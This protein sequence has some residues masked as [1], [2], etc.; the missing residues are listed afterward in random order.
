MKNKE[1]WLPVK[2]YEGM[3]Q[4]SNLGSVK[5]LSRELLNWGLYPFFSKEKILKPS[6]NNRGYYTVNLHKNKK[7]KLRTVHQLVAEAFLNHKPCGY[8]L[9]VNHIDQNRLNNNI[10][11]LEVVTQ[12]ENS[13]KRHLKSTSK[14]TGVSYDKLRRKWVS[15]ITI[16]GNQINLG[17][18]NS[19]IEAHNAYQDKLISLNQTTTNPIH[20]NNSFTV[21]AQKK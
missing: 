9:V 4:V 10:N 18:F 6:P 19:E 11:N 7:Q 1:V 21:V 16:R 17:R 3:Y 12:R 20:L 5:S 8:K 13:N 15:G 14:Y 2:G